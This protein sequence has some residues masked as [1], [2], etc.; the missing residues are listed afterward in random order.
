MSTRY[1]RGIV[2]VHGEGELTRRI[3]ENLRKVSERIAALEGRSGPTESKNT[4]SIKA[5]GYKLMDFSGPLA[6]YASFNAVTGTSRKFELAKGAHRAS[7]KQWVADD[8][9]AVI[10]EMNVDGTM[11]MYADTGL[12]V[13]AAFTPTSKIS[14]PAGIAAHALVGSAHT[15]TG[16]TAG[17]VLQATGATTFAFGASYPAFVGVRAYNNADITVNTGASTLITLNSENYDTGGFHSTSSNTS[18]LTVPTG[19]GG[20][21]QV[22]G[23]VRFAATATTTW[24]QIRLERN[25]AGTPTTA[26]L[27]A[28]VTAHSSTNIVTDV[29]CSATVLLSAG[30]YVELFASTGENTTA[31]YLDIY[32]DS[33]SLEMFRVGTVEGGT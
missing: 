26:N 8:T 22:I 11:T 28:L 16:L 9:G 10:L 2:Q 31:T 19:F 7:D 30:D 17:H 33:P 21:Y 13:G 5:D 3:N 15:A 4:L 24:R 12:T 20:Y 6:G 27:F 29:E 18:R 23:H 32:Y 25:S 14:F 1:D